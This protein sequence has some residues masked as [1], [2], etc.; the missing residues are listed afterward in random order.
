MSNTFAI[1]DESHASQ[2]GEFPT[3]QSAW[4]ELQRL[5]EIPWDAHPNRAPCQSWQ[6]CSR[7]YQIIEYDT[8]SVPWTPVRRHQGLEVSA[9]G[10]AWGP[11]APQHAV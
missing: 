11:D 2:H 8:S 1:E 7:D 6:T 10:L 3:L 9:K 5:S 4:A